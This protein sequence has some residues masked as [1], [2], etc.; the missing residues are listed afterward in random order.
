MSQNNKKYHVYGLGNALVDMEFEVSDQ[1][2][3]DKGIEKGMMTLIDENQHHVLFDDLKDTFGVVKQ[4][5]G[6]SAANT[7]IA[8]S[9][10]GANN[11]YSCR[12]SDDETGDFYVKDL[13]AAG[14]DTNMNGNRETGVTG[15]CL[16]MVTPDAERTMNTYL[17]VSEHFDHSNI[18]EDAI[19]DSTYL[20]IEGYLVTSESG[21]HAAIQAREAAKK[22]NTQIAMTFSDPAMTQF[23]KDGLV[24]MLGDGV[25]LLFCNEHEAQLFT[26]KETAEAAISE[27]AKFAP[28]LVVTLGKD[29]ALIVKD[30]ERYQIPAFPAKAIDTNGAG[31]MFAGAYLYAITHGHSPQ[32]AG[33][34]AS[35]SASELVT[36]FGARLPA[37]SHDQLK[38]EIL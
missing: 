23:F 21:R 19:A 22:A 2:L 28:H 29:G 15:K 10:F 5:S 31:D 12:V 30:G 24:E 6:G 38:Q 3:S 4:A 35:R 7:I 36:H 20:Y 8:A 26:G 16:V 9:Y 11:F 18:V 27:L 17:G 13:M 1:F 14:V 34:L 25:D 33:R 32:E 37:E